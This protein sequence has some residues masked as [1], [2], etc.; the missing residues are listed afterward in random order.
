[1]N[2]A[3]TI[4]HN[5]GGLARGQ[6][7]GLQKVFADKPEKRSKRLTFAEILRTH[8]ASKNLEKINQ[9]KEKQNG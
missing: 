9:K 3:Q 6:S 4:L 2:A 1:M 8:F 5:L 7:L